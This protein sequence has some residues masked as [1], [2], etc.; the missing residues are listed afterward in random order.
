[1]DEIPVIAPTPSEDAPAFPGAGAEEA[2]LRL[3][4]GKRAGL[5]GIAV[6]LS[7]FAAKLTAGLFAGSV[8]VMADAFNNLSDAGSSIVTLV[9]FRM[10][11]APPDREHPFGHGRMEY[12]SALVVAV[13]ILLAGLEFLKSSVERILSPGETAFGA[14]TFAVLGASIL[15]K[16]GLALFYRRAG[17]RT[18]SGT[19]RAAAADS[20]NDVLCT[21]LV[22]VSALT[23]RFTGWE[24][25]G[26]AGLL[27]ALFVLW[28]GVSI[29]RGTVSP[30][31]G[32][33]IGR[34]HV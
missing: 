16:T 32:Q 7:L 27:V 15:A 3:R 34:A 21:A 8:A 31:L 6:N 9:G 22:L 1:M 5:V 33:E 2:V 30:L 17:R 25:D 4:A 26:Y 29:L 20:R 23:A 18:D 24:I 11:A 13:M 19:L 14:L 12:V 28:S 10:A